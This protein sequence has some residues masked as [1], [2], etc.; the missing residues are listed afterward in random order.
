MTMYN[1]IEYYD[2]YSKASGSLCQYYRDDSA[3][4]NNNNI[5]DFPA[6]NNNT[7][8]FKFKQ[9]LT[10]QTRKRWYKRH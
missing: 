3:L 2:S 9:Q 5:I 10:R 7:A 4:D 8:S 1:L 6:D